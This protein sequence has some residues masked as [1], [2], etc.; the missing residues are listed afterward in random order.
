MAE[1][2][3]S[4]PNRCRLFIT[5]NNADYF[6]LFSFSQSEKDGSIYISWPDIENTTWLKPDNNGG[7]INL[8]GSPGRGKIS[9]H[10]SGRVHY[11]LHEIDGNSYLPLNG[12]I[13]YRKEQNRI[14]ARHLLTAFTKKPE[15]IPESRAFNR[16]YDQALKTDKLKPAILVFFAIP[17]QA[18]SIGVNFGLHVDEMEN[19][20]NDFLGFGFFPL[21]LHNVLW[22]AYR[23]KHLNNWPKYNY[24][25]YSD[26]YKVPLF[27]GKENHSI[28]YEYI[29]P[30]YKLQGNDFSVELMSLSAQKDQA[31]TKPG[32]HSA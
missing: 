6:Q 24:A 13:L 15:Y 1:D 17:Q 22:I 16:K 18:K 30:I 31:T 2:I 9:F 28:Q 19:I 29:N 7:L 20:P 8:Q 23:T 25:S 32:T 4:N 26:G 12:N 11:K 14:G 3:L 21:R 27:I 10:G 5:D